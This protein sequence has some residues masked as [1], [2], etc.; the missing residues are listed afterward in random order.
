MNITDTPLDTANDIAALRSAVAF[1]WDLLD[2]I[3]TAGDVAKENDR[4]YR[5]IVNAKQRMR[6][7][8]VSSD[9][10]SLFLKAQ[11]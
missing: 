6:F 5:A 11:S 1:L 3:D 8:R 9:G 4:L 2:D 7:D 10:Y